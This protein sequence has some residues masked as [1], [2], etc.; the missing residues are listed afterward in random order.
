MLEAFRS[1]NRSRL[2]ASLSAKLSTYA[3]ESGLVQRVSRKFSP[4]GFLMAMLEA[5]S[6]G[7]GSFT[8]L[9]SS[10]GWQAPPL[11]TSPQALHQRVNRT[12]CGV[13]GFLVRCLS[14]IC[15]QRQGTGRT[16]AGD[17]PFGRIIVGDSTTHRMPKDNAGEF[18][19]HGNASGETAGCKVDLAFD[20]LDGSIL[21]SELHT[22]TEQD[23]TIGVGLFDEIRAGDLVLRDMGYFGVDNF[24]IIEALNAF[25]LSRLPLNV[26]VV[27]AAGVP[28]EKILS[29]HHRD[30]HDLAV[31]LTAKGHAARL[32]A[33]RASQQET[34]KRRRARRAEARRKGR[35]AGKKALVRDGWH[36]M[37]T[38]VPETMQTVPQLAAIYSQR[39]LIEMAFRAWKQAGNM[40]KALNRVSSPQHLK[41]LVLAGMIAMAIALK[42]GLSLARAQPQFRYSLEKV[43]DYMFA[44][45]VALRKLTDLAELKPDPRHLQAQKRARMSL[46]C[47]LLELLG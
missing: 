17:C 29:S 20:L 1:S 18:P 12:E 46:N 30:T 41:G 21:H 13:E 22:A 16:V 33:V 6:T 25:W 10:L 23:K 9:V 2:W 3:K 44:R 26:D 45:L 8:Q 39:W 15:R 7:R 19:G 36:L 40:A 42:A 37:V 43:F 28:L 32:V 11:G 4:E 5:T 34:E 38:N 31:R 27:T 47:R 35:K 24:Q 14:H